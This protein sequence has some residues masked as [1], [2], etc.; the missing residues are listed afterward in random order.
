MRQTIF[1]CAFSDAND[2][3]N[4]NLT[5]FY[6]KGGDPIQMNVKDFNLPQFELTDPVTYSTTTQNLTTGMINDVF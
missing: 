5:W 1:L 3:N 2:I 6:P 4:I